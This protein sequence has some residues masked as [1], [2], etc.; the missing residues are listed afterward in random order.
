MQSSSLFVVVMI[1]KFYI[2]VS[3]FHYTMKIPY[4]NAPLTSFLSK[5]STLAFAFELFA[6]A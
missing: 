6:M 1:S 4:L 3:I 5:A 2:H